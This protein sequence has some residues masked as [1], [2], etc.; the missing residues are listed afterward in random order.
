MIVMLPDV[1]FSRISTIGFG[2]LGLILM[3]FSPAFSAKFD[4][5]TFMILSFGSGLVGG[6]LITFFFTLRPQRTKPDKVQRQ[7]IE[8]SLLPF[9]AGAAT[10]SLLAAFALLAQMLWPDATWTLVFLVIGVVL[11]IA[12]SLPLVNAGRA[13]LA[14]PNL[15]DERQNANFAASYRKGFETLFVLCLISGAF[16]VVAQRPF[17]NASIFYFIAIAGAGRQFHYLAICEWKDSK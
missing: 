5:E 13:S 3:V 1:K 4:V 17:P 12:T 10:G 16:V 6:A 14:D 2:A 7:K 15:F 11:L 8:R 9:Y